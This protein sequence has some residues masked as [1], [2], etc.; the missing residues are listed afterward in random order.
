MLW[1]RPQP[2]KCESRG[3]EVERYHRV[4]S[5]YEALIAPV[6]RREYDR[7]LRQQQ[8][9][10]HLVFWQELTLEDF[11]LVEDE[12]DKQEQADAGHSVVHSPSGHPPHAATADAPRL[13]TFSA[14]SFIAPDS[15]SG[16]PAGTYYAYEC[17]C[18][19][20][21]R[22]R[23]SDFVAFGCSELVLFCNSCS[24]CIKVS[25]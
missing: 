6:R 5:A 20:E 9:Q 14:P 22:V 24:L 19:D 12:D 23:Q 16:L 21:Y 17:R 10:Q 11:D 15:A 1:R 25:Q 2:D 4:E 8:Q 7:Q 13:A 3:T 18:G